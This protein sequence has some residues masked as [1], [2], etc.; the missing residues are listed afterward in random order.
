MVATSRTKQQVDAALAAVEDADASN[1]DKAQMLME[2]AMGLQQ[3][4]RD[5]E[6]L[7]CRPH[8]RTAIDRAD[9]RACQRRKGN[10]GGAV[11]DDDRHCN[12]DCRGIGCRDRR[13]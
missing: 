11:G 12:T 3:A 7:G 4:P 6:D 13:G 1:S 2:I 5:P 9:G 8:P 10:Q